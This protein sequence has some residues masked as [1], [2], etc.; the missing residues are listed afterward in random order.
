MIQPL[1]IY[2]LHIFRTKTKKWLHVFNSTCC[3]GT[4][5]YQTRG[6]IVFFRHI[7]MLFS[8]HWLSVSTLADRLSPLSMV[9]NPRKAPTRLYTTCCLTS[10]SCATS[11]L[12]L[13]HWKKTINWW[14]PTNLILY[15]PMVSLCNPPPSYHFTS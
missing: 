4:Y 3:I 12:P 1:V 11:I 2:I 9:A 5:L 15:I 6:F 10:H 8:A 7:L 13:I 14:G